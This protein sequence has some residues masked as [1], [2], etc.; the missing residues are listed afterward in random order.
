MFTYNGLFFSQKKSAIL[1][2]AAAQMELEDM[3]SFEISPATER[4]TLHVLL[5]CGS[6]YIGCKEVE[7]LPEP[8]TGVGGGGLH[9][10]VS[11]SRGRVG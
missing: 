1:S 10:L 3:M 5:G 11:G 2:S 4:Q 6:Q 7:G 8:R 9:R